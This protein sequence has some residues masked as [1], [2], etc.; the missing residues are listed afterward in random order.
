MITHE[1]TQGTEAW[2]ALRAKCFTA[3]EAP[4]MMGRS[5]Y[6]KR[7]DLLKQKATGYTP[8]VDEQ[9][10]ARFDRGQ[11]I[12]AVAREL[13][14]A[15]MGEDLFPIVATDDEGRL[16]ASFDGMTMDGTLIWECKTSNA[17]LREALSKGELPESHWPQV[18]QQLLISGAERCLFT[19]SDGTME[20]THSMFYK[21]Q[22]GRRAALLLGWKQFESDLASYQHIEEKPVPVASPVEGFGALMLQV[23]GRVLSCNIEAFSTGARAFLDRLP[24]ANELQSDQD[25]ADADAAVKACADAESR[26]KAA[27]DAAM[28]QAASIDEVFRA[29]DH[30]AELIRAARLTLDKAVKARKESIR[31]EIMQSAQASLNAHVSNLNNRIGWFNG[32][33]ILSPSAA[34]FSTAIKGKKTVTSLRDACETELARAKIATSEIADRIEANKKA[35]GDHAVLFPDFPHVCTKTP[36][37]FANLVSVRVQQ[38]REA[39]EAKDKANQLAKE[40]AEAKAKAAATA[41]AEADA[42]AEDQPKPEQAP[43]AEHPPE[44]I[45][46]VK[47]EAVIDAEQTIRAFMM[48]RTWSTQSAAN[49]ARAVLVEYEKFKAEQELRKAA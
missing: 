42:Q 6:T 25:F 15:D 49:N 48:S 40:E 30:V 36:D 37:D 39:E 2:H 43:V 31:L 34:D 24:K 45:S 21:S 4:A 29:V 28:A 32:C 44:V 11:A 12:E 14:E 27:K 16:L 47:K 1:V 9:T 8:D 5:P 23:E 41:K 35:M 33:P 19:I 17:A 13:V 26:I 18:E 46:L 10:Q 22:P 20:G 38:H 3:S 7:S